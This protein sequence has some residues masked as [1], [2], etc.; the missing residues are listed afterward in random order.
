VAGRSLL[1]E[2]PVSLLEQ[3]QALCVVPMEVG[4]R[5]QDVRDVRRAIVAGE[6]ERAFEL[7]TGV[8]RVLMKHGAAEAHPAHGLL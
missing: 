2:E 1:A 4:E 5:D 6:L 7:R 3:A 8:V